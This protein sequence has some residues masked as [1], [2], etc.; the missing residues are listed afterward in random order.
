LSSVIAHELAGSGESSYMEENS[1]LPG[2]E[3]KDRRLLVAILVILS[4]NLLITLAITSVFVYAALSDF[5]SSESETTA[6]IPL[7]DDLASMEDRMRVFEEFKLKYNS[8]DPEQ[9]LSSFGKPY[10]I[11]L[12]GTDFEQTLVTIH[13]VAPSILEG[14]YTYYEYENQGH[15]YVAFKLLYDI[16]TPLGPRLL[17]LNF[18]KQGDD[19]TSMSGF[20]VNTRD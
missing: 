11:Q 14:A 17:S 12:R 18:A 6:T 16:D 8:G 5:D 7:P 19:P 20:N 9:L 4:I 13:S 3:S 2:R 15:G 10:E 1:S